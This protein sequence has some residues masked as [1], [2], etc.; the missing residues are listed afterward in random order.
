M[1]TYIHAYMHTDIT[2][3]LLLSLLAPALGALKG[4][5][6]VTEKHKFWDSSPSRRTYAVL[7][8]MVS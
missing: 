5:V 1:Y 8:F 7:L 6:Y 3:L 2:L 4:R